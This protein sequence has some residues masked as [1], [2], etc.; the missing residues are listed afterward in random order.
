[1]EIRD[2]SEFLRYFGNVRDRTMKVAACVPAQ[3]VEWRHR[4]GAFSIG[5]TLRHIAATERWMFGENAA[6]RPS[7]YAGCG[8]ELAEGYEAVIE[9]MERMHAETVAILSPLQPHDLRV[10]CSVPGGAAIP[11]WKW[12]RAMIEHEVHHRGQL[13]L[14]LAMLNVATPPLYGLTSEQVKSFSVS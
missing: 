8:P 13:Y 1:M 3:Q 10:T 11:R 2:I 12:L 4:P 14:M 7:R 6:G 5:D 9:Y